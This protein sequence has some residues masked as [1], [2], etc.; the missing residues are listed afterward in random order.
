MHYLAKEVAFKI[1]HT[2]KSYSLKYGCKGNYKNYTSKFD[3]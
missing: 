2:L 3:Y 1:I